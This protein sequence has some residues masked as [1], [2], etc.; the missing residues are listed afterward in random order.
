MT[1]TVRSSTT[2]SDST[3]WRLVQGVEL[4]DIRVVRWHS[5]LVDF[6]AREIQEFEPVF[7]VEFRHDGETIQFKWDL[8]STLSS[9]TGHRV[10][11][12]GLSLLQT[13]SFLS[14]EASAYAESDVIQRFVEKTA[15][16]SVIPFVREAVQTMTVRL[17]LPAVTLGLIRA[18][19]SGPQVFSVRS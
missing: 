15:V 19:S 3:L 11:A 9:T 5:E 10:A 8:D 14:P 18:G 13:F 4:M 2:E 17:G 6:Q 16:I 1:E 7:S 12:L